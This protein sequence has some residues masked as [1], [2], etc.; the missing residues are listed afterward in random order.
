MKARRESCKSSGARVD[1]L[2]GQVRQL[3]TGASARS[4][5]IL[6]LSE[7][8]DGMSDH[9]GTVAEGAEP[10]SEYKSCIA[11]RS[12]CERCEMAL[13]PSGPDHFE[14]RSEECLCRS[15]GHDPSDRCDQT[16]KARATSY[17]AGESDRRR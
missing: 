17:G 6:L 2:M 1:G 8:V 7:R 10:A 15:N 3:Q 16:L 12:Y 5:P 13:T 14:P 11:C 9:R 4:G